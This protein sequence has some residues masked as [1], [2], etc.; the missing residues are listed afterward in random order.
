MDTKTAQALTG[1]I[2]GLTIGK[3]QHH[4]GLS[5]FPLY[6]ER[7]STSDYLTLDEA[8]NKKVIVIKELR[9]GS[10][11]T[12]EA[13]NTGTKD[14]LIMDGEEL[15]GAKQNRIVNIS[16]IIPAES[17]IQI[18]VSCVER[19]RWRHNSPVF[20]SSENLSYADLRARHKETVVNSMRHE[21]SYRGRQHQV[22]ENIRQ[23]GAQMQSQ[24]P[25][26]AM[27]D[28]YQ[29]Q[30]E[31]IKDG[32]NTF[33]VHAGQIGGV[34]ALGKKIFGVDLFDKAETAQKLLP[35]V[36]K[37]YLLET[38]SLKEEE[39]APD[40]KTAKTFVDQIASA[41]LDEHKSP[42][43]GVTISITSDTTTGTALVLEETV[44]HA[45]IFNKPP[46]E[47]GEE[48]SSLSNPSHRRDCSRDSNCSSFGMLQQ[49][50]QMVRVR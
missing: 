9:E 38:F 22:W 42:G 43:G 19:G 37:S 49:T 26:E 46:R 28:I 10:V 1:F 29:A 24:S 8:L 2:Q 16:M 21:G 48:K 31:R 40:M 27:H 44:I 12:I 30:K 6:S 3:G 34:F 47:S 32:L 36:I 50:A 4:A 18:P 33:Q 7:V 39:E 45:A 20:A 17:T 11:P 35:K 15:V 25:T 14:V 13:Q 23:K 41:T 5:V